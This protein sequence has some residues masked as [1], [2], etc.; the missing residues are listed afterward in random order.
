MDALQAGWKEEH[1]PLQLRFAAAFCYCCSCVL[2][3]LQLFFAAASV[4]LRGSNPMVL[5]G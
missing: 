3:M 1:P 5:T 2:L 4:L